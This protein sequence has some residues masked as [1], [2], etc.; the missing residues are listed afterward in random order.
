MKIM[1]GKVMRSKAKRHMDEQKIRETILE[2]PLCK[3]GEPFML[4]DAVAWCRQSGIG[5]HAVKVQLQD[6]ISTNMLVGKPSPKDQNKMIYRVAPK[7]VLGRKFVEQ[8]NGIPL[9]RY[10]P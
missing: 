3:E 1:G 4:S 10:Y 9:G 5:D 8:D 6:M 7:G 2:M